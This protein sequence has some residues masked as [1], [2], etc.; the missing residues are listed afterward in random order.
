MIWGI[1]CRK[2]ESLQ[3][4]ALESECEGQMERFIPFSS[5]L[6]S[7]KNADNSKLHGDHFKVYKH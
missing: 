4:N 7:V 6:S 2:I 3:G 1:W 5:Y